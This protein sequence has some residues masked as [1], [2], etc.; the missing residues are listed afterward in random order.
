MFR[1]SDETGGI[2]ESRPRR[3]IASMFALVSAVAVGLIALVFLFGNR[4]RFKDTEQR[5]RWISVAGGTSAAFVFVVL[6]P[7]LLVAQSTIQKVSES[8]ILGYLIHHSF[9]LALVGLLVFW[10]LDRMVFV[11]VQGMIDSL[12]HRSE[13]R[14]PKSRIPLWRPLLYV[15]AVAFAAYTMLVGYLIAEWP[16]RDYATL[17]LFSLAMALHFLTM[18]LSLRHELAE[19]YDRFERWLLAVAILA[20]WALA[21]LTEVASWALALWSS[22]FAGMIIFYV[23]RSEIPSPKDGHFLPL[24]LGAVGFSALA[25]VIELL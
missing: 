12:E 9:L 7:K 10:A 23:V 25:L 2:R 8:G 17:G 19:A 15:Q 3:L 11:L 14:H 24:L 6:L 5:K 22:L 16:S 20:G 1:G 4:I 13:N 18:S 21:Q